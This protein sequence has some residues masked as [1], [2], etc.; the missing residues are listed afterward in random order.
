LDD[1]KAARGAFTSFT[2]PNTNVSRAALG[3]VREAN[4]SRAALG[5]ASEANVSR[6]AL[7]AAR[8][9]NVSRAACFVQSNF[10]EQNKF[11]RTM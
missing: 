4:V 11:G 10:L 7:G 5:A 6:A 1:K 8:E 9:A 2:V 3:A